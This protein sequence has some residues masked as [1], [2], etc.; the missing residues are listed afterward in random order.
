MLATPSRLRRPVGGTTETRRADRGVAGAGAPG[1]PE[2]D[3]ALQ[4]DP[5]SPPAGV[6]AASPQHGA[7]TFSKAFCVLCFPIC[8][9]DSGY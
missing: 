7:F 3:R 4:R 8:G 5:R 1:R 9:S 2:D 6:P